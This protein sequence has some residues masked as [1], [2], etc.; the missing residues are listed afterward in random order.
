LETISRAPNRGEH[1]APV[2][3]GMLSDAWELHRGSFRYLIAAQHRNI[4]LMALTESD[5]RGWSDL[6]ANE[7]VLVKT[8]DN[9]AVKPAGQQL[10]ARILQGDPLFDLL[11][12]PVKRY[13]LPN[14]EEV[15][16]YHRAEGP[17]NPYQYPVI[18]IETQPIAETINRLWSPGATLYFGNPDTA[19][20]VGIHDLKANR[21]VMPTPGANAE[22]ALQAV[23]GTIFAVTRYDTPEVQDWLFQVGYPAVEMGD[24]EFHLS[25]VGRPSPPL[26]ALSVESRW[27]A[28]T[29]DALRG[30]ATL[31]PGDVLPVEMSATGQT[32]GSRKLSLRLVDPA[33]NVV[34]QQDRTVEA[35]LRFALLAPPDSPPGEY[36][37]AGLLYDAAT[38]QPIPDEAGAELSTLTTITMTQP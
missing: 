17:P 1:D 23:K 24:H 22:S 7:W 2:T 31:R 4:D 28:V 32:D 37:L 19:T 13:I 14:G 6:L 5:S 11:Y 20:W 15:I 27:A 3:F 12:Q 9:S 21:I 10:I 38:L 29:I 36:L 16:L 25:I 18:L 34:A 26:T 35:G 33:G 8:G 30:L